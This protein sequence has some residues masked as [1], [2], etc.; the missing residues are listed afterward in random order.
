MTAHHEK[1]ETVFQRALDGDYSAR[2]SI[3]L[4]DEDFKSL[5]RM[6]NQV[7]EEMQ[8]REEE[9]KEAERLKKRAEAF[10]KFNPQAIAVLASDKHR[11]DLNKE[12][13]RVWRG[14]YDELMAKKLY[15]FNI[16]TSGDDFYA[17]FE[18]KKM[19]ISDLEIAWE[20]GTTTY[21]RL[22]QVPILD[23][24]G[25][26]DVNYYIYQDLTEQKQELKEIQALQRRADAFLKYNP[27]AITVLAADKHRL[28]LNKEYE[29][30][31]R[32]TYD[33]L[34]AKKLYDF[35]IKTSGDDFYASFETKQM[36]ISDMEVAWEDNTTSYLRLFQVPILDEDGEID[37]NYYI[38]QDNT[39][40]VEKEKEAQEKGALLAASAEELKR[41]M[42][43]MA[44]GDLTAFVEIRDDDPIRDL[45]LNYRHSRDSIKTVLNEIAAVGNRVQEST[46]DTSRS[47]ADISRAIEEVAQKSQQTADNAKQQLE[48]LE[49]VA[50][51]MSD[52]SASIE[53]IASTA[54]GVLDGTE[55]AVRIGD[56]AEVIGREAAVKM[57]QVETI[58]RE[59]V[60][61]FSRL[62][63]EMQEIS[64]I[65]K[66]INDISSQTNLLALNAAIEAARAGEHGRG[67]AVVAGEVR[68]LAGESKNATNHIGDLI[69]SIQ[70]KS[71]KTARDLQAAFN[72]IE[73]GILSVNRTIE[74]LNRI[75]GASKEAHENVTEIARATDDQ[76]TSTNR[77]MERMEVTTRMTKETMNR[78]EDMAALAEEV[79]A[80]AEEVGSASEE[81]AEMAG[82]MKESIGRFRLE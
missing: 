43:E 10:V 57:Q 79:S 30:V 39:V 56:E 66:L 48:N 82:E 64:K 49:E 16:K 62:K 25:E 81:V 46:Q 77:V 60:E 67:F 26:I 33:E 51:A 29:R 18:T 78:I 68:N 55:A 27:Q 45:K 22:F 44:T 15:D 58:T 37:V 40:L 69:G 14:T 42:D 65:V 52:L 54:Q 5:G 9:Q 23:D 21:L 4:L 50:R 19:A 1:I 59:G 6:V 63:E 53:E 32:G 12:Y 20:D 28:D 36:A 47:A 41:A 11:L 8:R 38:Y 13:E 80:S 70:E 17:S 3:D 31:W 72:E 74:A 2:C 61:E 73:A 34:M 75:I 71:E 24:D 7:I 35:N 76:A